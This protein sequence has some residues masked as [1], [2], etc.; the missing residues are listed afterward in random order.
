MGLDFNLNDPTHPLVIAPGGLLGDILGGNLNIGD[1]VNGI[2]LVLGLLESGLKSDVLGKLP[3]IGHDI[4]MTG[5]FI[6]ELRDDFVTPLAAIVNNPATLQHDVR[7]LI[8]DTIGPGT[9][10]MPGLNIVKKEG[11]NDDLTSPDDLTG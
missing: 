5:F 2:N 9:M 3:L 4:N 10:A 11:S 6:Q 1:L 7:V 8:F